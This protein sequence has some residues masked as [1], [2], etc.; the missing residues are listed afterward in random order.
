VVGSEAKMVNMSR[1]FYPST[2]GLLLG[3][4][5]T[6]FFF[7]LTFAL[8]SSIG[9]YLMVTLC[10][11]LGS[12]IG[13]F[14]LGR[15]QGRTGLFL[16][17]ALGA[18]AGCVVLL[19]LNPFN[20]TL[21]PL[22]ALFVVATGFYPGVFFARMAPVYPARTLFLRENNGFVVGLILGAVLFMLTGRVALWVAPGII[23]ALIYLLGEPLPA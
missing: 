18:Y 9:T 4:L 21:W 11:L 6:G 2:V 20:S 23:A 1:R 22:Y 14:Y 8:S 13:V 7:Q 3:L 5:Q 19:G 12:A 10:W 16:A 17:L 15:R